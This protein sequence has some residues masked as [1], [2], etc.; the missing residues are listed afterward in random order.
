[1]ATPNLIL[2]GKPTVID[3]ERRLRVPFEDST[4]PL[5][6]ETGIPKD[7][8]VAGAYQLPEF[9]EY[10]EIPAEM[11]PSVEN[12]EL[13]VSQAYTQA[14]PKAEAR[15][16]AG[17]VKAG[18]IPVIEDYSAGGLEAKVSDIKIALE[19]TVILEK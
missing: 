3:G 5:T 16:G 14:L 8:T 12:I 19:K 4:N 11:E 2:K 9:I 1:M 15:A 17:D 13:L 6:D 7:S 18:W 10:I